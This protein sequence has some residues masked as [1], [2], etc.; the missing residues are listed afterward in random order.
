L[1]KTAWSINQDYP[2]HCLD[3][4]HQVSYM[5]DVSDIERLHVIRDIHIGKAFQ[6][7]LPFFI[8]SLLSITIND[9]KAFSFGRKIVC[10]QGTEGSL[11]NPAFLVGERNDY[12]LLQILFHF[13][14][15]NTCST[16]IL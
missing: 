13:N 3:V 15:T 10:E 9:K 5:I 2:I 4:I 6:I 16:K 12:A 8:D 1:G 14:N 11:A 7:T